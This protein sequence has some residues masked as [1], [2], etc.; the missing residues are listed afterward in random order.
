MG[1]FVTIII[2]RLACLAFK[3]IAWNEYQK[4]FTHRCH[5]ICRIIRNGQ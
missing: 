5:A 4:E 2:I 1:K 3:W